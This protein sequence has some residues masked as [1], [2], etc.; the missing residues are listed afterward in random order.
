MASKFTALARG[1]A[2]NKLALSAVGLAGKDIYREAREAKVTGSTPISSKV[3]ERFDLRQNEVIVRYTGPAHLINNR[4]APHIIGAR[5]L[6]SR[7]SI[8]SKSRGIS[9][10]SASGGS[11]RGAFGSLRGGKGARALK[12]GGQYSAYAFHPG[13]KGLRFHD[14]AKRRAYKELPDVYAKA[15]LTA[16]LRKAFAA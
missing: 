6:G 4:T 9:A 5:R 2:D 16:P 12:F 10:V 11:N 8:R 3:K 7:N 14:T 13:T 15:G 1:L